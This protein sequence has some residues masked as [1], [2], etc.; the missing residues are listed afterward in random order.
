MYD[1]ETCAGPLFLYDAP[2]GDG[3]GDAVALAVCGTC[4]DIFV[5]TV[6]PDERHLD[7]LVDRA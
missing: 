4:G 1:M 2:A 3:E 7:T 6:K 5:T